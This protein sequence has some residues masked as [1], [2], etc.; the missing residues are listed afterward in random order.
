MT[1]PIKHPRCAWPKEDPL[2]IHYHDHEW[3]VPL[4]DDNKLFEFIVL[5]AF[6]AGLSWKT[7]LHRRE[8]FRT[9]FSGFDVKKISKYS[10]KDITRLLADER[11]I[12]NKQKILATVKNATAFL[13][14]QKEFGGFHHFIWQFTNNKTILNGWKS[15]KDVPAR[16][17]ESDAMSKALRERGFGFAGSTICYAFMQAAGMVNDHVVHCFRHSQL[18]GRSTSHKK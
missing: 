18:T 17:A 5:D 1:T 10:E 2:M 9:A 13:E 6:Q 3:G 8:G 7:I 16:T 11:I 12:R 4:Y 14:I 15:E